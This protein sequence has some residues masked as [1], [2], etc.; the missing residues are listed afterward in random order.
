MSA[1]TRRACCARRK[2]CNVSSSRY[3]NAMQAV[4]SQQSDASHNQVVHSSRSITRRLI[5]SLAL[6][7]IVPTMSIIGVGLLDHYG[8]LGQFDEGRWFHFI[9]S[10]LFVLTMVVIWKRT[11]IWTLG[12][13]WLT[14]LIGM[15]PF[16]QVVYGQSIITFQSPGCVDF[17]PELM[18][19]SQHE[20]SLGLWIW[21]SVWVWW[22]WEKWQMS[23]KHQEVNTQISMLSPVAKRI[24]ASIGSIPVMISVIFIGMA[25]TDS[26]GTNV[27]TRTKIL[28]TYLLSAI[29]A[30][31]I[32]IFIWRHVV[33]WSTNIV[34]KTVFIAFLCLFLPILINYLL[35][36]TSPNS[37][38]AGVI[39]YFPIIGWGLWM[40][41][42]V[43]VWTGKSFTSTSGD[44]SPRCMKCGYLL[45][46]LT[47]TRCPECGDEPTLDVLWASMVDVV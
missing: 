30:V 20:M 39:F 33:A 24:V 22:G 29:V 7:P 11:I 23:G 26:M 14:V 28:I 25:L 12:R 47:A 43:H 41:I 10:T 27:S 18:R 34:R 6:L 40:A 5:Y 15:I 19:M 46:G 8:R 36:N 44:T 38:F 2:S 35:D 13:K 42:T 9:F 3:S 45:R 21:L 17:R 32:W 4:E 37:I 1:K 16:V 31:V